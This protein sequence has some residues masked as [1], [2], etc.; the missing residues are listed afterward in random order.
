MD[1]EVPVCVPVCPFVYIPT[2]THTHT[3]TH[4]H[5]QTA[6][7]TAMTVTAGG[8]S[9]VL[10][11][12][13]ERYLAHVDSKN[14]SATMDTGAWAM[15]QQHRSGVKSALTVNET[16]HEVVPFDGGTFLD[17]KTVRVFS[18]TPFSKVR[19]TTDGSAPSTT[20]GTVGATVRVDNNVRVRALGYMPRETGRTM[21]PSNL[22]TVSINIKAL[23]PRLS[24][25][26]CVGDRGE[27]VT[28][29]LSFPYANQTCVL[30]KVL[31]EARAINS[32][33]TNYTILRYAINQPDPGSS[34]P[35]G[36]FSAVISLI[37]PSAQEEEPGGARVNRSSPLL[38]IR[39]GGLTRVSARAW[40]WGTLPSDV[41][42]SVGI[43]MK[44]GALKTLGWQGT[45]GYWKMDRESIGGSYRR[46]VMRQDHCQ[47]RFPT[48][49]APAAV[50][51][52][53]GLLGP[54]VLRGPA[55]KGGMWDLPHTLS[56]NLTWFLGPSSAAPIAPAAAQDNGT[57]PAGEGRLGLRFDALNRGLYVVDDVTQALAANMFP[58]QTLSVEAALSIDTNRRIALAGIVSARIDGLQVAGRRYGKGWS[59]AYAVD[60]F[61]DTVTFIFTL[62][63]AGAQKDIGGI[64]GLVD[65]KAHVPRSAVL[66]EQLLH[67][68]AV[69]DGFEARIFLNGVEVAHERMC[70]T[71]YTSCGDILYPTQADALYTGGRTV[72][73]TLGVIDSLP[74]ALTANHLGSLRLARI[75]K[76]PLSLAQ[77]RAAAAR[78]LDLGLAEE[79][80]PPGTYGLY[81]GLRPCSP[82]AP[83]SIAVMSASAEC[84]ACAR[85]FYA[86][87]PGSV[88][89]LLCPEGSSTLGVGS[90]Q[91]TQDKCLLG[92][93]NCDPLASCRPLNASAAAEGGGGGGRAIWRALEDLSVCVR[94]DFLVL[95][96]AARV[97]SYI[98]IYQ[99]FYMYAYIYIYIL[100]YMIYI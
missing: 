31:V 75:L 18:S 7:S 3:H 89:C 48:Y 51:D 55:C 86:P 37:A 70:P 39:Q 30:A 17:E 72:S 33:L 83:G 11:D 20:L 63:V 95:E 57:S 99:V 96:P 41:E 23:P 87:E 1:G 59:L 10:T 6:V 80:C 14:A 15:L 74:D 47:E 43:Y 62:A 73:V 4:T 35:Q 56:P 8:V 84:E 100:H 34:N 9:R 91:C 60:L 54:A 58:V 90:A 36:Q 25:L 28:F 78:V 40:R 81:E 93:H 16:V 61:K 2:Y 45:V 77:V 66:P 26:E 52:S 53:A 82:C 13:Y 19:Y 46:D 92:T 97:R 22:S 71:D 64:A 32:A 94:Q 67:V 88:E 79:E 76:Q 68:V 44:E 69:Y 21:A 38:G 50:T 42:V 85:N 27:T 29:N 49:I 5:T 98:Y 24:V 65:V 12:P